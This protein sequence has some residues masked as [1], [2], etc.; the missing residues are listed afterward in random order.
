MEERQYSGLGRRVIYTDAESITE[1]NVIQELQN[2]MIT[3]SANVIDM[4]FLINFEKGVQP[5]QREKTVRPDINIKVVDNVVA[6]I[7]EFKVS[8]CLGNPITYIQ[9]GDRTAG[10]AVDNDAIYALNEMLDAEESYAT[11]QETERMKQI[12]GIANQFVDIK[13]D[14]KEGDA[15]FDLVAL[16]PRTSF[17]VYKNDALKRKM[18]GVTYRTE[19]NGDRHFTVFTKDR[20]YE[21]DNMSK[22]V[23]G[24]KRKKKEK[25]WDFGNR[26]GEI[27][28]LG[29][30][31]IVEF[32]RSY[33]RMGCFERVIA[34]QNA[35]NIVESDFI[36]GISQETQ[37]IWWGNDLNFPKDDNGKI[38]VP[39][40]GQWILS[41]TNGN[42]DPKIQ[43]LTVNTERGS[44]LNDIQYKRDSIKSQCFVP[45]TSDPGGGSTGTAY[46]M[47]SG[48]QNAEIQA[49]KEELLIRKGKMEVAD[50]ILRAVKRSPDTP[51]DSPVAKL[52]TGDI[53]PSV[54]RNKTY[55]M[56]TKANTLATL[57][58]HG[59]AFQHALRVV[60]LFPDVNLVFED[61]KPTIKRY[62]D[63]IYADPSATSGSTNTGNTQMKDTEKRNQ[64][65]SS[66]QGSNSPFVNSLRTDKSGGA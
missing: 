14:W 6:E 18:M 29:E 62:L 15:P 26:S 22:I 11:D 61:S 10:K 52:T 33:D 9:R 44:I 45:T 5:L 40:T 20:R 58:S 60:E 54:T 4:D 46:S 12:C 48:W 39:S 50:L 38:I 3:H 47:S 66:D 57:V 36:N 1:D 35:L 25:V 19:I 51:S 28:P 24:E 37:N 7:T 13:R 23:N 21:I 65:D 64:Q 2:A 16:D 41:S 34:L 31:P 30:I 32:Q 49:A 55:D 53:R 43:A 56:A 8:Y 42:G 59:V 27:N 63:K 17:V